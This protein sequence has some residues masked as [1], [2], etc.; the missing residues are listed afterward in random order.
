M[1]KLSEPKTSARDA[2]LAAAVQIAQSEGVFGLSVEK[3]AKQAGVSK[4]GFFYHFA[5]KELMIEAVLNLK[6]DAFEDRVQAH[7]DKGTTFIEALFDATFEEIATN[8]AMMASVNAALAFGDTFTKVVT[9]RRNAWMTR[10]AKEV[11]PASH[12]TLIGLAFDG[13]LFS[14]SLRK[15]P[16]SM[17]ELKSMRKAVQILMA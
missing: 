8:T 15:T 12:A 6:L 13:L 14:C 2:I 7:V 4:G 17:A 10:L 5:T 16:P 1:S 3:V 11:Q 9:D